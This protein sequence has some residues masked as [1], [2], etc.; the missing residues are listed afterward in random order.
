MLKRAVCLFAA[1]GFGAVAFAQAPTGWKSTQDATG[2]CHISF[3]PTWSVGKDGQ[4]QSPEHTKALVVVGPSSKLQPLSERDQKL[5]L[6]DRLFE[7]TARRTFYSMKPKGGTLSYYVDV[8]GKTKRCQAQIEVKP[9]HSED[10]V[11]SIAASV[12]EKN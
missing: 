10:E 11:K 3:P 6:V 9:G 1:I 8:Q 5:L 12:A 7:N 4:A 2:S